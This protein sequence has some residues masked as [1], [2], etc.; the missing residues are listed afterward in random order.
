MMVSRLIGKE[1]NNHLN[2]F[3]DTW[4]KGNSPV[5]FLEGFPGTGKT[6]IARELLAQA[7]N[8]KI[9]AVLITATETDKDP[10]DDLLLDLAMEL[11]SAGRNELAQA[12]ENNRPLLDVLSKIVENPILIPTSWFFN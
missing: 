9:T 1:H 3:L 6:M 5:C 12:I 2:W 8:S 7:V 4:M 10:T 11:N